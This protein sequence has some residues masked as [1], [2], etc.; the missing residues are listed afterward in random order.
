MTPKL[1]IR[2]RHSSSRQAAAKN[3]NYPG[4]LA[5]LITTFLLAVILVTG[6]LILGAVRLWIELPLLGGWRFCW[7]CRDCD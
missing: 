1:R 2:R 4:G 7:W 5:A 6:P 3:P